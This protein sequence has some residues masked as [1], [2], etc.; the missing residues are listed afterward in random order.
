MHEVAPAP[1]LRFSD[2]SV[3]YD[4]SDDPVVQRLELTIGL[5]ERVA[6]V[7][8]S[9]AG[10]STFISLANGR[11]LPT[12]GTVEVLGQDTSELAQRRHRAI[13]RR[14]GTVYQSFALVG[15][16]RVVHNVAAGRLGYWGRLRALRS[17]LRPAEIEAITRSLERVGIADKLWDRVDQLS[18]GQQQRVAVAR[19]L[20]QEPEL[21]LADEPVSSLDPTRSVAV[22]DALGESCVGE[23]ERTLVLSLHDPLLA[24]SHADRVIGLR[25]GHVYFD[26]PAADVTPALL[27]D[28]YAF[29]T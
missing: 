22:L 27:T 19:A 9:G 1:A 15:P 7:G 6:L 17:L 20:F 28:L 24:A 4:S 12:E 10:K 21:L 29:E 8:P 18:G 26:L 25:Q 23:P 3:T 11:V 5:G 13:R 16:L 14:V 2:V